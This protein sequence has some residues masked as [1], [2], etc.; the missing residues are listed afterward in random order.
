[1]VQLSQTVRRLIEDE[2]NRRL[3]SVAC[4]WEMAF[5]RSG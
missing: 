3:V 1:M 5:T 4:L 2:D